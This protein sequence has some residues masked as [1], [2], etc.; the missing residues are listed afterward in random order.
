M[1]NN[2]SLLVEINCL[3]LCS[4]TGAAALYYYF[5]LCTGEVKTCLI[6]DIPVGNSTRRCFVLQRK[7]QQNKKIYRLNNEERTT[8]SADAYAFVQGMLSTTHI[9]M[10]LETLLSPTGQVSQR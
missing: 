2:S 6:L 4:K 9:Y 10:A 3:N 5:I 8:D 7:N 1:E